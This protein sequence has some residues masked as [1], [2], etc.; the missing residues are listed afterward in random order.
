MRD[1]LKSVAIAW[2]GPIG[3]V[4]LSGAVFSSSLPGK[5]AGL[6]DSVVVTTPTRRAS[7]VL[8]RVQIT[9]GDVT[10]AFSQEA[11]LWV[12]VAMCRRVPVAVVVQADSL[13]FGDAEARVKVDSAPS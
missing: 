8:Q 2:T 11:A 9:E 6:S 3:M 13:C 4:L 5:V 10:L 7:V 12:Y 1:R